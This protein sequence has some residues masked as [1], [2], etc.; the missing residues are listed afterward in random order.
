M[1]FR[2][3]AKIRLLVLFLLIGRL[4][5][6]QNLVPNFSFESKTNCPSYSNASPNLAYPW[7]NPSGGTSDYFNSCS[8]YSA[9]NVPSNFS[10]YQNALTGQAYCGFIPVFAP[11]DPNN[12]FSREYIAVGLTTTLNANT[13]YFVS[14]NLSLGDSSA[15]GGDDVGVY[16]SQ[17]TL[18]MM[19]YSNFTVT[20][21]VDNPN[22]NFITNKVGWVKIKG[23][24]TANGTERFMTIGNFHN[25]ANTDS[26]FVPGGSNNTYVSR[27]IYYY[28]DDVCVSTDSLMCYESIGMNE[29]S[30]INKYVI[31]PN[32]GNNEI[33]IIFDDPDKSE[34]EINIFDSKGKD[35]ELKTENVKDGFKIH[36]GDLNPQLLF[37]KLFKRKKLVS[38]GKI[39]FY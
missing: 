5:S 14:L 39:A 18:K 35:V 34:Y 16:F 13:K 31:Y 19:G 30:I 28:V 7:Y 23:T 10:G 20:P 6:S 25:S 37:Y 1:Y 24:F 15:Y 4:A 12:N 36:R 9:F 32:P 33:N 2:M 22:G 38:T 8:S 3:E 21:Q 27:S 11:N 17:D 26:L 29:F